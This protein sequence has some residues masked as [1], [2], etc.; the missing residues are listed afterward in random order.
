[1]LDALLSVP[2]DVVPVPD[3]GS[4]RADLVTYVRSV[5]AWLDSPLGAALN[6]ALATA[7]DDPEIA[8][9]R[10]HFW[11]TRYELA[12]AMVTRAI[13]RGE[14]PADTDARFLL[15]LVVSPLHFRTLLTRQPLDPA[16][17]ERLVDAAL[18]S[19]D[20]S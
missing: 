8:Q 2:E 13:G 18:R 9:A 14:L 3:T 16:M 4:L 10:A 6:R 20:Q 12:G 15:E 19:L 11:G 1:M 7:G 17:P 5:A